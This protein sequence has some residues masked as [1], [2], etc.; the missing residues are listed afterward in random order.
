MV[1]WL[2]DNHLDHLD[3]SDET[4]RWKDW[5]LSND[6]RFKDWTAAWRNWMRNAAKY[7]TAR[8]GS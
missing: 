5:A 2:E 6:R 7:S 8:S 1:K 3:V 4:S